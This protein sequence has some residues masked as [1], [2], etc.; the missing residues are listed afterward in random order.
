MC[1]CRNDSERLVCLL[2]ICGISTS[3]S[4]SYSVPPPPPALSPSL[5]TNFALVPQ[6]GQATQDGAS[7]SFDSIR[8]VKPSDGSALVSF[9]NSRTTPCESLGN[10]A[11]RRQEP[12]HFDRF[13]ELLR[14]LPRL[15]RTGGPEKLDVSPPFIPSHCVVAPSPRDIGITTSL[16]EHNT[17]LSNQ[18]VK[19]NW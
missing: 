4:S 1:V 10:C 14:C 15:E 16:L 12:F 6:L 18:K 2:A 7:A 8:D 9:A 5:Q 3:F 13:S 19:Y 11:F 17:F